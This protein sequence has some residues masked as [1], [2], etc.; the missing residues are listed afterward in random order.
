MKQYFKDAYNQFDFIVVMISIVEMV[1][2]PPPQIGGIKIADAK[3]WEEAAD[4]S[5]GGV[6]A[7]RA[8]RLLRLFRL[9]RTWTGLQEL[10]STLVRT[11]GD[12]ANFAVLMLL[13]MYIYALIG[14]QLFA[15]RFHYDKATEQ[16]IEVDAVAFSDPDLMY[17]ARANFDTFTWAFTT[18]FQ[19]LSGENWNTV[20]YD[21]WRASGLVAPLY[22]FG[23]VLIGSWLIL[24]LFLAILLGNFEEAKTA[25]LLKPEDDRLVMLLLRWFA[26]CFES[27]I[28]GVSSKVQ[29]ISIPTRSINEVTK[30][31]SASLCFENSRSVVCLRRL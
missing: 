16:V 26:P 3:S 31:T 21:G 22:F 28:R 25:P 1:I 19:I 8:F 6:S 2:A 24:N 27:H 14:M 12:V 23:L 9:A 30:Y 5:S 18:I 10:L 15:H 13:F 29:P 7:L 20:M 11:A 17:T 4:A